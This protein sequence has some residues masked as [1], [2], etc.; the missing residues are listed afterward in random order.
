MK[1][2]DRANIQLSYYLRI[3]NPLLV[4]ANEE[5]IIIEQYYQINVQLYLKHNSRYL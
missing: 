3:I 5:N 2:F 1:N 4:I